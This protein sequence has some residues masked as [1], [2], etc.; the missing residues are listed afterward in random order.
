MPFITDLL[1]GP[2]KLSTGSRYAVFNGYIY[3]GAGVLFI[4]WPGATQ[5][6]SWIGLLSATNKDSSACS[7]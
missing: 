6:L 1:E 2:A 7:G 5:T 4:L 3:L